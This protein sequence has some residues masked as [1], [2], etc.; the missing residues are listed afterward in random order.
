[1]NHTLWIE[2]YRPQT[3]SDVKG[4]DPIVSKVRAFVE[5]LKFFNKVSKRS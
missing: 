4:Q 3:F 1:M 2:K 5:V